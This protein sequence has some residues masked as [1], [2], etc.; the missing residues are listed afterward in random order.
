MSVLNRK[1]NLSVYT[2]IHFIVD[3]S[4]IFY[5]MGM[6]YV[7][8]G[9]SAE[10]VKAAIVY[11]LLAFGAPMVLGFFVDLI[12]KNPAA[13]L[14][15]CM[16]LLVNYLAIPSPWTSVI[17]LGL[18][19]G[20]FHLGGGRQVLKDSD[21]KYG[22]SGIFIAAGAMGVFLGRSMAG[23]YRSVYFTIMLIILSLS[24]ALLLYFTIRQWKYSEKSLISRQKTGVRMIIISLMIFAVVV[25]R[26]YYGCITVYS[27]NNTF[28]T[29]LIFT[30]C[31][32]AGKFLGG[33]AADRIGVMPASVISLGGA[34][35][36]SLWS[37]LSPVVGCASILLFNMTMPIT[38]TLI[39]EQW[40]EFP[41]FAF[42]TLMM[43]LFLGTLPTMMFNIR[44][45]SSPAGM[46][47]LCLISLILLAGAV[48]MK[49]NSIQEE[50]E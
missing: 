7:R 12:G 16:I 44:P 50:T 41:G 29:G 47:I 49:K 34:A 4:C 42:G 20:L 1:L 35:I 46:T 14:L 25:I 36:L 3:L 15:G 8:L 33:I 13:S 31:V 22:P 26:S 32:A 10:C 27:W 23:N 45:L 37:P 5:L 24:T 48:I 19:N 28:L 2:V 30:L 40:K 6:V 21:S 38:L 17:I 43:A 18:G 11:N 39:A 9:S